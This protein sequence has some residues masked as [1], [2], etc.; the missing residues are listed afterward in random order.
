M[1]IPKSAAKAKKKNDQS[2]AFF[3]ADFQWN[4]RRIKAP[5][6]WRQTKAGKGG[7]VSESV[8][9]ASEPSSRISF[10]RHLASSFSNG[11]GVASVAPAATLCAIK[12]LDQTGSGDFADVLAGRPWSIRALAALSL[13][14]GLQ[15]SRALPHL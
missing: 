7:R 14:A 1:R 6:A 13:S 3:F 11:L 2:D 12:V 15:R 10:P 5:Q 4:M 9:V 8:V